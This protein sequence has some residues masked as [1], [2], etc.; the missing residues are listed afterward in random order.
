[1]PGPVR[2]VQQVALL[3][4]REPRGH[5]LLQ[6]RHA[7]VA[8]PHVEEAALERGHQRAVLGLHELPVLAARGL[9]EPADDNDDD[10]DENQL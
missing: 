9:H 8:R 5:V 7:L 6:G 3:Q 2:V 10:D 4:D 1:M